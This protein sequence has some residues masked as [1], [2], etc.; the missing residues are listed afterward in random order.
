MYGWCTGGVCRTRETI[1]RR[2]FNERQG[3]CQLRAWV[4]YDCFVFFSP[5]RS[6]N[7][8][9]SVS[10]KGILR[11]FFI[12]KSWWTDEDQTVGF[13]VV[14]GFV[15]VGFFFVVVLL[16]LW[17]RE[18]A[19]DGMVDWC[20][21]SKGWWISHPQLFNWCISGADKFGRQHASD[22]RSIFLNT[23]DRRLSGDPESCEVV[24]QGFQDWQLCK[25]NMLISVDCVPS[26]LR[27]PSPV[28]PRETSE[29]K[30]TNLKRIFLILFCS[31]P[32][33]CVTGHK[34]IFPTP[35]ET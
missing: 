30:L 3:V 18:M 12:C 20:S 17:F 2:L 14:V 11:G 33:M 6:K 15:F 13:F 26:G 28:V 5:T 4:W 35:W 7:F 27:I 32:L 21:D 23:R 19:L 9:Y 31:R 8:N 34:I 10:R 24:V 22:Q 29:R 1:R 16:F 25:K